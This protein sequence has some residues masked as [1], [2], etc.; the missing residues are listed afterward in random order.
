LPFI[1][2]SQISAAHQ[3]IREFILISD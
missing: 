3:V 1:Y 2:V